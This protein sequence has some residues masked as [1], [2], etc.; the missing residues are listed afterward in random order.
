[1]VGFGGTGN[2]HQ[3][4]KSKPT[5]YLWLCNMIDIIKSDW[6]HY[7]KEKTWRRLCP[8]SIKHIYYSVS[9]T[10]VANVLGFHIQKPHN[11]IMC[12]FHIEKNPSC[13]VVESKDRFFCKG[14][15]EKWYNI[16]LVMKVLNKNLIDATK[17]LQRKF[18]PNYKLKF[19]NMYWYEE[20]N[21][22]D[23]NDYDAYCTNTNFESMIINEEDRLMTQEME[24]YQSYIQMKSDEIISNWEEIYTF[25]HEEELAIL[26][27]LSDNK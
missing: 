1:M 14:C 5:N 11:S 10:K 8:S 19:E 17:W 2:I 24:N 15:W 3:L 9:I 20:F 23:M 22:W 25:S 21:W 16:D 26:S 27:T 12:P 18:L 7:C 13:N 4:L 6:I